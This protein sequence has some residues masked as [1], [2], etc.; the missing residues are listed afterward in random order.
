M[1]RIVDLPEQV[2]EIRK[3]RRST[4]ISSLASLIPSS[5]S[6]ASFLPILFFICEKPPFLVACAK[7]WFLFNSIV[8]HFV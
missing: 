1:P 2:H 5:A 7:K 8:A 4:F 3:K 6:R